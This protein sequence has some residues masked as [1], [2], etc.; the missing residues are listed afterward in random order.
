[1]RPVVERETK[2]VATLGLSGICNKTGASHGTS[3]KLEPV[4]LQGILLVGTGECHMASKSR[5]SAMTAR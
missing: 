1:M 2:L 3:R 4:A 5:P